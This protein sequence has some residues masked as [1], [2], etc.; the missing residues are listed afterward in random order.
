MRRTAHRPSRWQTDTKHVPRGPTR[1][2][3]VWSSTHGRRFETQPPLSSSKPQSPLPLHAQ[4]LTPRNTHRGL[5][6]L[7]GTAQISPDCGE[8]TDVRRGESTG[9]WPWR[10]VHT[11]LSFL[12]A[13]NISRPF[14]PTPLRRPQPPSPPSPRIIGH[15]GRGAGDEGLETGEHHGLRRP[16]HPLPHPLPTPGLT[17]GPGLGGCG[18][19]DAE[20]RFQSK[21]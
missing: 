6:P 19:G 20:R 16:P 1:W 17:P 13:P 4:P 2:R 7:C 21:K 8:N 3:H 15:L 5:P 18:W 10:T 12:M 14:P 9:V 11:F